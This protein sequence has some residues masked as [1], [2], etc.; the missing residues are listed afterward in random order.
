LIAAD[1][2]RGRKH[3][4]SDDLFRDII[5][6]I[7]I[8]FHQDAFRKLSSHLIM[9]I[10]VWLPLHEVAPAITVCWEWSEV[11]CSNELWR[12]FYHQKFC[13]HN[14]SRSIPHNA[15]IMAA[16][17]DQLR[18]PQVGDKVEVSWQGKFR[19]ETQGS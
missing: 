17:R 8:Y 13:I 4:W 19:L 15:N 11:A 3:V 1:I 6:I 10:L 12:Y 5:D 2:V 7:T 18:N 14:P 16:F 9:E